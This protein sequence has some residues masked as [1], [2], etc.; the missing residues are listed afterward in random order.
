MTLLVATNAGVKVV[1]DVATDSVCDRLVSLFRGLGDPTTWT[2]NTGVIAAIRDGAEGLEVD[3]DVTGP[4]SGF[5]E[6]QASSRIV[7]ATRAVS[8]ASGAALRVRFKIARSHER[9]LAL[10]AA[11]PAVNTIKLASV[12][13][14]SS[15]SLTATVTAEK[16]LSCLLESSAT[17]AADAIVDS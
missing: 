1:T 2:T 14:L 4:F 5:V 6:L 17:L 11:V 7:A 12:N 15:S 8:M 16:Q 10:A 3:V 9:D 13:S